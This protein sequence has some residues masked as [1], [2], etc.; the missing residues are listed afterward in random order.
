MRSRFLVLAAA[1]SLAAAAQP[2]SGAD[3]VFKATYKDLMLEDF[4]GRAIWELQAMCAG[5][6]RATA[7][8]WTGK[9]RRDRAREAQVASARATNRVVHQLKRDRALG[10]RNEAIELAAPSEQV[11]WRITNEALAKDGVSQDGQWNFWR[12]ACIEVD[13]AFFAVNQ[14]G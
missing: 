4:D 3:T 13:R 14:G 6:H 12:S 11:G 9:G 7:A 8:Y 1:L 10:D 2:A 5:F